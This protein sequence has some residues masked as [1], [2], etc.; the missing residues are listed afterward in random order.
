VT[1][2]QSGEARI[3]VDPKQLR[4]ALRVGGLKRFHG[5]IP[6]AKCSLDQS[7]PVLGDVA[8]LRF[9]HQLR[10]QALRFVQQAGGCIN[11]TQRSHR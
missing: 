7:E 11:I 1:G 3:R 2:A 8:A 6:L 5:Q 4:V 9:G 10:K